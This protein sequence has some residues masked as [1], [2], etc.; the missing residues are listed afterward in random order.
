MNDQRHVLVTG[1]SGFIGSQ[2]VNVLCSQNPNFKVICLD[3][4]PSREPVCYD[5][6]KFIQLDI[7]ESDGLDQLLLENKIDT[8]VHLA[9]VVT[10]PPGMTREDLFQIDVVGTRNVLDAAIKAKVEQIIVTSSGAAYGYYADNAEWI[11]EDHPIRGNESFAYS[12]HKR[13]VE[14]ML[15]EYRE[16]HPELKQLI[17]RP[18]TVLGEKVNNQ[19]TDLFKKPFILGVLSH[20]SPFVFIW[21]RDL[22]KIILHGITRRAEGIF[23]VAGDGALSGREIAGLLG[24]Q[25]LPLPDLFLRGVL[26][27]LNVLKLTQ[28]GPEQVKFIKYRPVLLNKKL[29]EEFGYVPELTTR[30]AFLSWQNAEKNKALK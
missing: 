26:G 5:N 27:L 1:A 15:L 19:I 10:P 23:N 3:I 2:L 22:V 21:D 30:D 7:R 12:D 11:T 24:K 17:L 16:K 9:S 14:E 28:Y 6:Y 13:L 29:K 25:Y 4:S 18:G 20:P 8:I